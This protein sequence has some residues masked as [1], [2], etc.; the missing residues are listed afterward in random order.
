[1]ENRREFIFR[2][3]KSGVALGFLPFVSACT[4][5]GLSPFD[6]YKID[7]ELCI[8]CGDC[9]PVC[10][11]N[12]IFLPEKTD[13]FINSDNCI[14]CGK[15]VPTCLTNAIKV[16]YRVYYIDRTEC[17]ECGICQPVCPQQAIK[18]SQA[19]YA[20]TP[21][22][23][24]CGDCIDVCSTEGNCIIYLK[25]DYSVLSKCRNRSCNSE[26]VTV[27][28]EGAIIKTSG[29]AA[30]IDRNKC[31]RCGKCA[32][33]CPHDAI[34]PA[35]VAMDS[36]KCTHC[37]KCYKACTHGAI[38]K[39]TDAGYAP[40]QIDTKLCDSC[41][42]C[43]SSC[44][45]EAILYHSANEDV[46]EPSI[47]MNLCTSCGDCLAVCPDHKAIERELKTA[48]IRED[49]CTVCGNCSKICPSL[50]INR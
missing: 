37:G 26:C 9:L 18:I 27:C 48:L 11:E 34:E 4:K 29:A 17:T 45:E 47:D 20:I 38:N 44:P 40:P 5:E 14:E 41:G 6:P 24:G 28:P 2:M 21:K 19:S 50:A 3:A 31:T 22:C 8:G 1:M 10:R 15:C 36:S 25:A 42:E 49:E 12:A 23:V 43:M 32:A 30:V 7:Q 13:Y 35:V 33:A 46:A 39:V 16:N